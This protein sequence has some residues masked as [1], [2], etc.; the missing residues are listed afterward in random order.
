VALAL[1]WA[2]VLVGL[3]FFMLGLGGR[4]GAVSLGFVCLFV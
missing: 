1:F 2:A 3:V 4:R